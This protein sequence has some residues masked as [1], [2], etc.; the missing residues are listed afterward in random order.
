MIHEH[1]L[2]LIQ[3]GGAE[4]GRQPAPEDEG[5]GALGGPG[6]QNQGPA[7]RDLIKKAA[8]EGIHISCLSCCMQV[9]PFHGQPVCKAIGRVQP[10]DCITSDMLCMDILLWHICLSCCAA[11]KLNPMQAST[12]QYDVL[13]GVQVLMSFLTLWVERPLLRR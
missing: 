2:S 8:P 12:P 7:L 11:C 9:V 1:C 5:Y 6:P 10:S 3:G 4:P 13:P